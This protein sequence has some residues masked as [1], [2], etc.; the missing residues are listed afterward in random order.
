MHDSIADFH[1]LVH[2]V[3]KRWNNKWSA[4]LLGEG[5][6]LGRIDQTWRKTQQAGYIFSILG[7]GTETLNSVEAQSWHFLRPFYSS[8]SAVSSNSLLQAPSLGNGYNF[9]LWS[10]GF[11]KINTLNFQAYSGWGTDVVMHI[12]PPVTR[13]IGLWACPWG[14]GCFQNL[15]THWLWCIPGWCIYTLGIFSLWFQTFVFRNSFTEKCILTRH[16][17]SF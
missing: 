5:K 10:K 1:H 7:W 2:K 12:K 13:L 14:T 15:Q 6:T 3:P 4:L 8:F 17:A 16:F 9:Y 11:V